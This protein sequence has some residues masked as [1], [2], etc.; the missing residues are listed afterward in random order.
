MI[1]KKSTLKEL[2]QSVEQLKK[3]KYKVFFMYG[4]LGV[5][6]TQFVK[7]YLEDETITSPTF[8]IYN[9]Y[10]LDNNNYYHFDLY[11][12]NNKEFNNIKT[13]LLEIYTN[14][15]YIFIE[16]SE[17]LDKEFLKFF[18]ENSVKLIFNKKNIKIEKTL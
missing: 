10:T 13:V 11:R 1:Y 6:K 15:D 5:G 7:Y 12:L 14:N 4:D 18:N 8:S 9:H 16:W 17:K 3:E 2:K